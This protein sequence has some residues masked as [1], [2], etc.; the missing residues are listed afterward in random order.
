[1]GA[2]DGESPRWEDDA[3]VSGLMESAGYS[4][5]QPCVYLLGDT[6]CMARKSA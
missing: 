5:V 2:E 4:V 6:L 3:L 1:M